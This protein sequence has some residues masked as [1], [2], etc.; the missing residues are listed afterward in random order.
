[1]ATFNIPTRPPIAKNRL[2]Y[3]VHKQ[4]APRAEAPKHRS[5]TYDHKKGGMKQEWADY[6]VFLDWLATEESMNSMEFILSQVEHSDSL[7]WQEQH[8]YWCAQEYSGGKHDQ[9][10]ITE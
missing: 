6:N 8:V 3:H 4:K 2:L 1:M 7:I 10:K 5:I 9:E